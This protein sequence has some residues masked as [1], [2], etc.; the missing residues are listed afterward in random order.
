VRKY[1]RGDLGLQA[2][3]FT[4]VVYWTSIESRETTY[5]AL[6]AEA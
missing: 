3:R 2:A 1:L 4:V 5:A 6:P